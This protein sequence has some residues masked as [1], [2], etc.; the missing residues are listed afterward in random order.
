MLNNAWTLARKDLRLF[1]R[2]RT[3]LALALALPILLATIFGSAMGA[4]TGGGGGGVQRVDL[5]VEDLDD[6]QASRAFI[7]RCNDAS[8]LVDLCKITSLTYSQYDSNHLSVLVPRSKI[9]RWAITY[10]T[11]IQTTSTNARPS[12]W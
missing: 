6:S 7:E 12:A 4:M 1:F 9:A 5:Q 3:A 10:S 11:L 8:V 2:D